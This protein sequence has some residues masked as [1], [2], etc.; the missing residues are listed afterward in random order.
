MKTKKILSVLVSTTLV[1]SLTACD[2][3][4]FGL[5]G[6]NQNSA[7]G[8]TITAEASKINKEAVF[9]EKESFTIPGFDYV[10]AFEA[11]NGKMY[12]IKTIY[13]DMY[14]DEDVMPVP[15]IVTEGTEDIEADENV[16][17]EPGEEA[18]MEVGAGDEDVIEDGTEYDDIMIPVEDVDYASKA[19]LCIA[20]F[21]DASNVKEIS[22]ELDVNE[23]YGGRF[24]VSPNGDFYIVT[25][26]YADDGSQKTYLVHADSDGNI[27]TKK[28]LKETGPDDWFW[29]GGLVCDND[30]NIYV[31]SDNSVDIYN[32]QES[33]PIGT[34]KIDLDSE[35][36]IG[37]CQISDGSVVAQFYSWTGDY[38]S[39]AEKLSSNGTSEK[40]NLGDVLSTYSLFSGEGYDFYYR[41][42]TSYFGVNVNDGASTEVVN[43]Y[44][45]DLDI[46]DVSDV[47]FVDKEHFY[48]LR[49]TDFGNE[50]VLFEKVPADQVVD[51]EVIT[52]GAVYLDYYVSRQI[53]KYNKEN[54]KYKIKLVDY[55]QF[56]SDADWYAGEK[57]LNSDLAT[58]QAPDII[59]SDSYTIFN[60]LQ[61]GVF[62]DL[63]PYMEKGNG[64]KKSDLVYNAQNLYAEGD[65]LYCI[66]PTFSVDCC[67]I[68]ENNYKEG[69]TLD[70]VIAWENSTGNK[71]FVDGTTRSS[72]IYYGT[73]FGMGAYMD[74][75][76]GKCSFD[77]PEFIKLLEYAN[78]YPESMPDDFYYDYDYAKYLS[79]FKNNGVLLYNTSIYSFR[80]FNRY[81]VLM[82]DGKGVPCGFPI[83]GSEGNTVFTSGVMGIN[84]KCKNKEAA[85]DF[86]ASC[87]T[88]EFYANCMNSNLSSVESILDKQIAEAKEDPYWLNYDGTKEYYKETEWIEGDT[89][90]E[91][92]HITDEAA[93]RLK[94]Y[95]TH[96][97]GI[98]WYDEGVS[99]IIEEE[100]QPYFAGQKSASEVASIIQSR[101]QIYVNERQ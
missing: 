11:A 92:P 46:D 25:S 52:I 51:K 33:N 4:P 34:R 3:N 99:G 47:M 61:K 57:R 30:G 15:A 96:A 17:A 44:D 38:T 29:V 85:W 28:L 90:I 98:S 60:M 71:A 32:P 48:G 67:M 64:I 82:M 68:N 76:T 55:S 22:I 8:N 63:T 40:L 14:Y 39:W 81:S 72:I 31:V 100:I 13:E 84:S 45:S 79:Q 97:M 101:V 26:I 58:G 5:F 35:A 12:A 54:D 36:C 43:F 86:I 70:D 23:N 74:I 24:C 27:R 94:E 1:L 78:T 75:K 66:Y 19:T 10:E 42:N 93:A 9:K 89:E 41:T 77:S 95:A 37:V 18:D 88:E 65:K 69:M 87:F 20:E 83:E 53:L 73:D 50:F 2:F 49:Y 7:N 56:N 62:E 16:V 59:S 91:I 21:T 6:K 80:D